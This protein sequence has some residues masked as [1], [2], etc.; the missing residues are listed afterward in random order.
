MLN[1]HDKK[2]IAVYTNIGRGHPNYLDTTVRALKNR[3]DHFDDV[4]AISSVFALSSGL[5]LAAWKMVRKIYHAGAQGGLISSIYNRL[6]SDK[7]SKSPNGLLINLLGKDLCQIFD[8]FDGLVLVAHPLLA[9]ILSPV[10]DVFYIHGEIASPMEFDISK[11]KKI[12][13]PLNET[14]DNMIAGGLSDEIFDITGLML[15]PELVD[16]INQIQNDRISRI[17]TSHKPAFGFFTSGAYPKEHVKQILDGIRYILDQKLG[18]VIL[19]AGTNDRMAAK[20]RS[21]FSGYD[22]KEL[23]ILS[24]N[25]RQQL[26]LKEL[27]Y[28]CKLD[29]IV[30]AAHERVNWSVALGIPSILLL[31]NFG[32]YA[33]Q[34]F[35]F[36]NKKA[37]VYYNQQHKIRICIDTFMNDYQMKSPDLIRRSNIYDI[38]GADYTAKTILAYIESK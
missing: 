7:N 17:K 36:T 33:K 5:S 3:F 31:P 19:S 35:V 12:F 30:F 4:T 8:D 11:C 34:N 6:R 32:N 23:I 15:E 26:T 14:A 25:E 22:R 29:L 18:S 13:V 28:L 1:F 2:L 9:Q 16:N 24:E 10:C 37:Q 21:Y 27:E 20:I 38:N